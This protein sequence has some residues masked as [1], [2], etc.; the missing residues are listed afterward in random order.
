MGG[1]ITGLALSLMASAL[2]LLGVVIGIHRMKMLQR[3]RLDKAV[4][5]KKAIDDEVAD[6]G[7]ADLDAEFAK[8]MRRSND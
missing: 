4:A 5:D 3:K 8:W 2:I 6:L 1:H 7:P